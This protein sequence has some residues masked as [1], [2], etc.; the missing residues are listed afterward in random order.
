[1]PEIDDFLKKK[2]KKSASSED[3]NMTSFMSSPKP[4]TP[5]R[6]P[7]RDEAE[8]ASN[9]KNN[10]QQTSHEVTTN[11]QQTV[12]KEV[13][14]DPQTGGKVTVELK[15][16][17]GQ[18][19][20]KVGTKLEQTGRKPE[21]DNKNVLADSFTSTKELPTNHQQSSNATYNKVETNYPQ[22]YNKMEEEKNKYGETYNKVPTEP[23]TISPTNHQQSS[24]KLTTK[25][26]ILTLTGL[27]LELLIFIYDM[28]KRSGSRISDPIA[29]NFLASFCKTT[30]KSAQESIRRL[31]QKCFLNRAKFK[32]GR[33]GWTQ[34][35]I[36]ESVF[37]ELSQLESYNKL[38]TKLPQTTNKPPSQL[39]TEP[40]TSSPI[41]VVSSNT[42]KNTT[43]T[44]GLMSDETC[45][46]IPAELSGKVSR[47]QLSE[48][49]LTGKI[50]ESDLQLS[51]DAFAYDLKNKLVSTKHTSNPVALLIGAIKNNGSYNSAKFIEALKSEMK[52]F[53]QAQQ[54]AT[55]EKTD[56]RNSKEWAEFQK[57][58]LENIDEYK[59]LEEKPLK[60]GFTGAMLED[61][62]FL[63]YK[64]TI[65]KVG[66]ETN[67]NPLRPAESI[68]T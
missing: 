15:T 58:K 31:Q 28:C 49:V 38:P 19:S 1:M 61:F 20:E 65:L 41:V 23:P 56:Q 11:F 25:A 29:I 35:S 26:D 17:S 60:V 14:N 54:A 40:P 24:Y 8:P 36:P 47:R 44:G 57:F 9:P 32:N 66:D 52:P 46:V 3:W 48:F 34:Y 68:Q 13:A 4:T 18:A 63:E 10:H 5:Q 27:Q 39:T 59:K 62:T 67:L 2:K 21:I 6:R 45:F 16:N 64:N 7:G 33:G 53:I 55:Q 42:S 51:L 30:A 43:N 12:S 22:T 50:S 37:K